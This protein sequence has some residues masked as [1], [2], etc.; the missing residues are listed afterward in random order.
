MA[1]CRTAFYSRGD[2]SDDREH[3]VAASASGY[4]KQATPHD[5]RIVGVIRCS[6]CDCPVIFMSFKVK[7]PLD[8]CWIDGWKIGIVLKG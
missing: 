7:S 3:L 1:G 8:R 6:S 5:V 4:G 2:I